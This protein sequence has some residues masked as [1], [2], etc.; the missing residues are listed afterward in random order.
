MGLF[1][2]I[3]IAVLIVVATSVALWWW[4][5]SAKFAPYEDERARQQTVA[6]K[7]ADDQVVVVGKKGP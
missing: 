1:I 7:P 2:V 6:S 3:I 4:R 5:I